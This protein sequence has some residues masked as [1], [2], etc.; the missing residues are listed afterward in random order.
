MNYRLGAL[1]W[2]AG[3]T[4]Q[5][6]GGVSNAGL[7]DQRLALDWIQKNIHLFGGDP[8]KVTVMGESAGGGSIE[9]QL[10]AF[11]GQRKAPFQ[12]IIPQSPGFLPIAS[13]YVQENSTQTFLSLLNVS[14]IAEARQLDSSA[15]ISAN[16]L[17]VGGAPYGSFVYG[18]VA[19]G[20]F[21]PALPSLLLNAGAFS[22]NISVLVGHNTNE[23]P[24][25]T[26]P[27][28]QTQ[29]Q[30]QAFLLVNYP[31]IPPQSLN[32]ILNVLYPAVFDGT[33]GYR[34]NL[35]RLFL[36]IG[37]SS[38]TC[39]TNYIS[40]AYNNQTYNYEFEV[41]PALHGF[42]VAYTFY[43]GQGTNISAGL[44]APVAEAHQAY[45]TNFVKTGNPNGVGVPSFPMQG[46]N[47]SMNGLNVTGI[48]T[49]RDPT[50][51]PR[52]AWWQKALLY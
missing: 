28:V 48:M 1:G 15:V 4:L 18:P 5:G 50:S 31:S 52:C 43:N 17:Q 8:N 7:Y 42:D 27:F 44:F 12:Q 23:A 3:P 34:S 51:N 21:A 26:P 2:L 37:E 19:D 49:K 13:Q 39:N 38:F 22:K 41:P 25:F 10:T 47:A 16:R 33:Y 24:S 11:G 14:S 46:M 45:I 29:A 36:L 35:E 20:V 6:A 30:T 32:Y 40:K 9:F